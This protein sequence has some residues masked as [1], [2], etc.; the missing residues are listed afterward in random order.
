ML[1]PERWT[2]EFRVVETVR[3]R[4]NVPITTLATLVVQHG[5]P[6]ATLVESVVSP[7]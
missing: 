7:V 2:N 1:E 5:T 3:R 6:G 4:E